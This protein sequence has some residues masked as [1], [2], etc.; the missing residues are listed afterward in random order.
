VARAARHVCGNYNETPWLA[1][2]A[3][4]INATNSASAQVN[5]YGVNRFYGLSGRHYGLGAHATF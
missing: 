1:I 4:V 5:R 2:N 3:S